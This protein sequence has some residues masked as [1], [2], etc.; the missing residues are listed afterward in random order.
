MMRFTAITNYQPGDLYNIIHSSYTKLVEEYPEQWKTEKEKWKDF[1]QQAFANAKIGA[2]LFVTCE[3]NI[4]VGLASWDPRKWPESGEIGQ[5]CILPEFQGKGYG[6]MQ[7]CEILRIFK[8]HYVKKALVTTSEH[9]FF[10]PAVKMYQ[11]LGFKE[12]RRKVGG[13]DSRFK[14]IEMVRDL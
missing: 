5:N 3:N 11:S 2:C 9:P 13:P 14:L 10:T 8:E 7:I 12:V 4:P 1:D 6:K